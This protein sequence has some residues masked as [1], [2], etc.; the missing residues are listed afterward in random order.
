MDKL[1][2]HIDDAM[3]DLEKTAAAADAA[4]TNEG[5]PSQ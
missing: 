4:A 2:L 1:S 3:A 5:D